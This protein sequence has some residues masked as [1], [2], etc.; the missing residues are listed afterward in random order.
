MCVL[1][2]DEAEAVGVAGAEG[3]EGSEAPLW[4]AEEEERVGE[5]FLEP[6]LERRPR[7]RKAARPWDAPSGRMNF[8][9][10]S[11][12]VRPRAV[13]RGGGR[14]GEEEEKRS[15][16]LQGSSCRGR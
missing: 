14:G 11:R 3:A 8:S 7:D 13:G 9:L 5:A 16:A 6:G 15:G 10:S 1:T 12:L 2:L 4:E